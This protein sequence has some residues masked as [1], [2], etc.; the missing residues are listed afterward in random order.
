MLKKRGA[1]VLMHIS[2]M[3]GRYGI[4][5]FDENVKHFIDR[6]SDIGFT[7]WQVL[8]FNPTD[9]SNSPYC[10]PSAFAGNY[11]F[12]DPKG[13]L[14]MGL[15]DGQD[16]E[17]NVYTGSPY[18]A[19]YDFAAQKRYTLLKKAFSRIDGET[20]R[21]I[22]EFE[23]ANPWLTDYAVYMAAKEQNGGS[24]WWQWDKKQAVYAECVKDIYSFEENAAFWKFAQ[25]IFYKQW[26]EI[27][28][29]A[30]KKG[31]AVIGDMPIYVAAKWQAFRRIISARTGS[32]GGIPSMTGTR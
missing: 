12:I 9:A 5:V 11:L 29:Y 17:D 16:V 15:V 24:A 27:K 18:T 4:G 32:F 31:V 22:K 10:S 6:I 20:A 21:Q 13:L 8:P 30:N 26:Y 28:L 25:F 7:Y 19:D 23:I 3:P 14:D 2:S 1:G